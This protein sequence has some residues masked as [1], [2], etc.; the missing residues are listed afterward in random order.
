MNVSSIQKDKR[1]VLVV[2]DQ[3]INRE[4]LGLILENHYELLFARDGEEA[5]R[6][7]RAHCD[8]L[9]IILLDLIMPVKSGFEVLEELQTDE[10]L[11][12]I[13]VIVLTA[14]KTAEL[15]SLQLG[16]W[17]FITK[18]FDVHEI[19]LARV[20]RMIELSEGRHLIRAAERDALTGFYSRSFFMEYAQQMARYHPERKKDAVALDIDRFHLIN[21][22]Y[23]REQ[24]DRVLSLLSDHIRAFLREHN[25]IGCRLHADTFLLYCDHQEDYNEPLALFQQ[26][27]KRLS[28]SPYLH[29]RVGVCECENETE[30]LT[31]Y[32]DRAL[33]ACNMLRGNYGKHIMHFNEQLHQQQ[34][35]H[36]ALINGLG[37]AI[38]EKQLQVYFQPKYDIRGDRPRLSSAEALVRW[39]HPDYG[40]V[41][42][43]E[44]IPLFEE[45]GLIQLVDHYVWESTAA[46]IRSWK[47]RHGKTVPV[48]V[49]LSRIDMYDAE[50]ENTLL[51]LLERNGLTTADLLLEVTESA[52]SD[53]TGQLVEAVNRLRGRGFLVEMDDFGSGYSSLNMLASMPI[54]VLK[55]DM[56]FVRNIHEGN[57]ELRLV[58]L[59]LD[60]ARFLTVPVV[61]EGVETEEQYSLLRKAG[62]AVIQGYYFS[63]PLPAE[64]FEAL[65]QRSLPEL[66]D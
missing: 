15:R 58:E 65:L 28:G 10:K 39:Q 5:L 26:H 54:D 3:E 35:H 19:I 55:M 42:P 57:K 25:G 27:L 2:D 56:Q 23:G 60:T 32:F 34:L 8:M 46:L 59:V 41:S 61:A 20:S 16:A 12:R 37:R 30:A 4:L 31:K 9:S 53:D 29:L 21:E 40:M 43:G 11:S 36:E 64:E 63:R 6:L 44:F 51:S 17:D 7:I 66:S 33:T 47:D 18:P 13:P 50:L 1:L 49:N 24:G 22:L 48:S 14:D 62:C 52:Y 45:N 38:S